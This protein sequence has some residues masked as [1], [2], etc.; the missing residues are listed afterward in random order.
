MTLEESVL[1][2]ALI[3]FGLTARNLVL[4]QRALAETKR[5]IAAQNARDARM[6]EL[7]KEAWAL[8]SYGARDEAMAA[9]DEILALSG[10]GKA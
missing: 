4:A 8:A 10:D 5:R 1:W 9:L 2:V 6:T 3:V 7:M